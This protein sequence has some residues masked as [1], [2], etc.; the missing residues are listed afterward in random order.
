MFHVTTSN[1]VDQ[2]LNADAQLMSEM[3]DWYYIFG[4]NDCGTFA[5]QWCEYA[6]FLN[7]MSGD[8]DGM[9]YQT[10]SGLWP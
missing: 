7:E 10:T 1:L 3:N 8:P 5:N 9:L 6:E 2:T 4:F